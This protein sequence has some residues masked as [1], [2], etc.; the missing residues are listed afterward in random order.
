M[1]MR[2]LSYVGDDAIRTLENY[3]ADVVFFSCRGV[4]DDGLLTDPSI[5][6]N[7][8]RRAMMKQSRLKIFL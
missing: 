3:N 2:S 8:I 7:L 4:S 5:E 6:E 1:L